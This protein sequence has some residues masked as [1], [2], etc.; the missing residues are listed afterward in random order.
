MINK[1]GCAPL[2]F[3]AS[4]L[5]FMRSFFQKFLKIAGY[6]TAISASCLACAARPNVDARAPGLGGRAPRDAGPHARGQRGQAIAVWPARTEVAPTQCI[7]CSRLLYRT[8]AD[9]R[10]FKKPGLN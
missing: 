9:Q 2:F 3:V 10:L 4:P 6:C 7:D 5:H 8:P 1:A